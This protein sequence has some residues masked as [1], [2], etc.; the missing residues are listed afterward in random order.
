[1]A[2]LNGVPKIWITVFLL[3][4]SLL[5]AL[6][7]IRSRHVVTSR[8]SIPSVAAFASTYA[9]W[10]SQVFTPISEEKDFRSK[11][12]SLPITH[13]CEL[14]QIEE[15]AIR[16][17]VYRLLLAFHTDSYE[18]YRAFRTPVPAQFKL[19][20]ITAEKKFCKETWKNANHEVPDDPEGIF[21]RFWEVQY[22]N[23]H[24][25]DPAAIK[26]STVGQPLWT[27]AG[28]EGSNTKILVEEIAELPKSAKQYVVSTKHAGVAIYRP[29]FI[30]ENSP[31]STL[32]RHKKLK[33]ATVECL[34][35]YAK[36]EPA[37]PVCV[38]FYWD[39]DYREWLPHELALAIPGLTRTR[40]LVF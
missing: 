14:T 21:R 38:L 30:F 27:A 37:S 5:I 26:D 32:S 19:D 8:T 13:T 18:N 31:E 33:I 17:E 7:V 22:L 4:A 36:P 24:V 39:P 15:T 28:L 10:A 12:E 9:E 2:K 34:I 23:K 25:P 16:Q 3:P 20:R 1:M 35:Q 40:D 29:S 6:I 11:I